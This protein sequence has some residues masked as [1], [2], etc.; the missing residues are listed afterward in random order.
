MPSA[1]INITSPPI[2]NA[3]AQILMPTPPVLPSPP[4]LNPTPSGLEMRKQIP[5]KPKSSAMMERPKITVKEH[6]MVN[7]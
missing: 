7:I 4:T 2:V 1:S 5:V 6:E 3:S